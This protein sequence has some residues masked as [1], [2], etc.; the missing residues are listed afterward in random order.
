MTRTSYSN[1]LLGYLTITN[2]YG[3]TLKNNFDISKISH[4]IING[5]I[6]NYFW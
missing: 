3:I 5:G 2:G 6:K 4:Q 1:V